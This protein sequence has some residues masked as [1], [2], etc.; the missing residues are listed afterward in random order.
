MICRRMSYAIPTDMICRRMDE[1]ALLEN[2]KRTLS[3]MRSV[4]AQIRQYAMIAPGIQ[5][6]VDNLESSIV[7]FERKVTELEAKVALARR[8]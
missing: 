8:H 4:Q 7:I 6:A 1:E 5:E 3:N 2:A